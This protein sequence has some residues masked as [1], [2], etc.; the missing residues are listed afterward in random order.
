MMSGV[1]TFSYC[2]PIHI[3]YADL[4]PQGH[5]NNAVYLTYLESARLGYYQTTGIWDRSSGMNTGM[6]V[7][8]IDIDYVAPIFLGQSIQ[9][10]LRMARLGNKSMT[11]VFQINACE[12]NRVFA[13][14][15]S[16]LVVYDNTAEE[17]VP[18]PEEWRIRITRFEKQKGN[19]EIT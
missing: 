2:H 18:I 5:V 9:V 16:I 13:R 19:H 6:V 1:E 15:K 10:G 3:R 14:G 8:H 11:M 4:D 17:S 7:A 12:G